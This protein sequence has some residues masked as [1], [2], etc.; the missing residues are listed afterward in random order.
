MRHT[1]KATQALFKTYC[2]AMGVKVATSYKD[3][4]A[5]DLEFDT[6]YGYCIIEH[7]KNG[8]P[9]MPFGHAR[10]TALEMWTLLTFALRTLG[11]DRNGLDS[12]KYW[13]DSKAC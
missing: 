8:T 9:K 13:P 6:V 2:E 1:K 5:W 7:G 11:I 12:P 10:Y 4:G 3:V